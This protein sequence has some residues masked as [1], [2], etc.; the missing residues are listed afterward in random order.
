M[1]AGSVWLL[2]CSSSRGLS[3]SEQNYSTHK[4]EFLALK[5]AVYEKFY[6]Y[7]YG[8]DFTVL[9]DNNPITYVL[10]SAK[11]DAAGH[12]WLA[13]LSTYHINFKYYGGQWRCRWV[14][15]ETPRTST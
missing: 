4:L 11:L 7:L 2:L 9:T 1:P 10:T 14:V 6:D 12:R 3:K 15:L 8:S 5:W 13:A